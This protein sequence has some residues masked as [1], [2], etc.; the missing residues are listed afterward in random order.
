MAF[1]L[2]KALLCSAPV[3]AAPRFDRPFVLQV[4]ASG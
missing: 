3:L 4:D 2:A 1:K